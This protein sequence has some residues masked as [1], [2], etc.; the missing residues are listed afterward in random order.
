MGLL[1]GRVILLFQVF[2]NFKFLQW[3][4]IITLFVVFKF[5][6]INLAFDLNVNVL[7]I[8]FFTNGFI[9]IIVLECCVLLVSI[10]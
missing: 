6:R 8:N 2:N 4:I 5:Q 3:F 7:I 1:D 9:I 10:H